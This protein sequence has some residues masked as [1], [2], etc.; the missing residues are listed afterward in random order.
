MGSNKIRDIYDILFKTFGHQHWWPGDTQFEIILG[1][2]LT[3]NTSWQ[4]V[5]KAIRNI[6]N[7]GLMAAAKI[8][9]LPEDC[10][11]Q[12]IRPAGYFNIKTKRIKSLLKWLFDNYEG[13]LEAVGNLSDHAL[14]EQLLGI[15]G[16]G[17]ETA[18]SIMLYAFGRAVFVVDAYTA[19]ILSRHGLI[20]EYCDYEQLRELLEGALPADAV[21]FNEYHALFVRVGKDY[22]RPKPRCA[23]CPLNC[24]PIVSGLFEQ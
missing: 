6:K 9:A 12:L 2:I 10:L 3:Q 13:S 18:D 4:N 14:R 1:A 7:A 20:D 23:D 17:R 19:R 24:L 5:E 11:A 22:C 16:V 15:K 8:Y 21:L